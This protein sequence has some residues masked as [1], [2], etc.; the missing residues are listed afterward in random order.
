MQRLAAI[1]LG[2]MLLTAACGQPSDVADGGSTEPEPTA[3][4][5]PTTEPEPT[6]G[7]TAGPTSEPEPTGEPGPT[8]EP[9]SEGP[10]EGADE[11]DV[12]F[13]RSGADRIWIE[14]L[15]VDLG[16]PTVGIAR[17]AMEQLVTGPPDG[18]D[19]GL[20][21]IAPDGTTV[22]GA[23]VTDDRVLV[24][25]LGGNIRDGSAA[26]SSAEAA[27]AEQLAYTGA[28]FGTV[29]RVQLWVDG[30]PVDELWG[31]V[32]WS[33]PIE[34][35]EFALS[36]VTITSHSWHEDV[37]AGDVTVGGKAT[38]FEATV[39]LR[40]YDPAGEL[41][42]ETFTTA[43]E[44]GPGRGDWEH[45]FELTEPGRWTIEAAENDPSD[46]EGREPFVAT[47]ELEVR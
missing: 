24:I 40:L 45:T 34:P 19:P 8:A 28:Q 36:P 1:L 43:S 42:E 18:S 2:L 13:A 30:A 9:T 44:G 46:G 47:L 23:N 20:V 15:T 37:P 12:Y 10:T 7:P 6:A 41:V 11:V 14:P 33:E 27:F 3:E 17:A 4:P 26:G 35:G 16:G 29:D 38:V 25:D 21:T 32:D 5:G 31:H 22:L 39:E